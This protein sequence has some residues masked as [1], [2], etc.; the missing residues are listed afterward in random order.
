MD[1]IIVVK[2]INKNII[3]SNEL[4]IDFLKDINFS[5]SKGE[6][7]AIAGQSGCGKSTL[8]NIIL[9]YDKE[10][11]GIIMINN[12]NIRE[13][14]EEEL[15][16][17]RTE[18][19][20]ICISD[21]SPVIMDLTV[22][23]NLYLRLKCINEYDIENQLEN[24]LYNFKLVDIADHYVKDGSSAELCRLALALAFC[25]PPEIV[26]IDEIIDYLPIEEREELYETILSL[27]NKFNITILHVT[28]QLDLM[29]K[30]DRMLVIKDYII[31]KVDMERLRSIKNSV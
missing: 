27:K 31:Y 9:G 18:K 26:I 28:H 20:G 24:I 14:N 23:D 6:L 13:L 15:K 1:E 10:A 25:G 19:I 8:L 3:L 29:K 30:A 17:F 16:K 22:K 11:E 12:I 21:K 4:T 5:V 2:G 7:L